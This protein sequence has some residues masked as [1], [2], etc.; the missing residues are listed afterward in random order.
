MPI[1]TLIA[2]AVILSLCVA[3]ALAKKKKKKG[4]EEEITQTLPVL[5]DPP[6]SISADPGRLIFKVAP[7]SNKG[8]L[9]QQVR[10]AL[11]NLLQ[12]NR[13]AAIVK[14]RA[15]VAGTG[16]MRRVQTIVSE[17]F[18]EKHLA[19]PVVTT[20]QAGA[21]PMEGAQV[22]IESIAMDKKTVHADGLAFVAAMPVEGIQAALKSVG[23]SGGGVLRATCFVSSLD[24]AAGF[25]AAV[26]AAF[27]NAT[28]EYIQM[29]RV[30]VRRPDACE[31]VA[32]LDHAPASAVVPGVAVIG[33]SKLIF[34]GTQ[35]AF[36][37][38]DADIRL[39]FERLRKTLE[40]ANVGY[41]NVVAAHIYPLADDIAE[42]TRSIQGEFFDRARPPAVSSI[43]MEGLPSHDASFAVEVIAVP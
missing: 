12:A 35:M 36:H 19:L 10:D 27:P 34:T 41:K 3:P 7:L 24:G 8:L 5:K 2:A 11:K 39:A 14:L 28:V 30:P 43:P 4:D 22:E 18:T 38:Q 6:S 40:A 1:R 13:G 17:M 32:A 25:R 26:Q 29:Q 20:L 33:G 23:L 31:A 9:S 21:L 42:K 15:F 16:D 37:A